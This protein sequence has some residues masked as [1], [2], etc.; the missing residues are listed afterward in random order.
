VGD[1]VEGECGCSFAYRETK[2]GY[3]R[4]CRM[5]VDS[6]FPRGFHID[7]GI[8]ENVVNSD[9]RD[10]VMESRGLRKWGGVRG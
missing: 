9:R 8:D 2:G 5:T 3:V 4:Q 1:A 6:K 7:V 10:A